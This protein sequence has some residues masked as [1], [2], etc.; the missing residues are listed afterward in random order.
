MSSHRDLLR[1]A[2]GDTLVRTNLEGVGE[3]REGKVRDLYLQPGRRLLVSTDRLSAFD[4][5]LATIPYKGQV[6]NQLAAWWF[7]Q[8][9]DLVDHHV[10]AVPDPNVTVGREAVALPVEIVVR[11]YITGVT[12]TSLWSLYQAGP[13]PYGLDLPAGL[14]KNDP[15]PDLV[16][17]PTTKAEHGGHDTPLSS[18]DV[19]AR[20]LVDAARWDEVCRTA[21]ALFRRGQ[22]RAAAAGMILVDTKYEM[23]L[24]GDRLCLI[25]EVHTP[26]SSRWWMADGYEL[27]MSR[28]EEPEGLD[29]EYV[30]RW[31]RSVGYGGDGP[32]PVM[33][34]DVRVELASRYVTAWE[35]LTGRAFVPA[36]LPAEPRI[37]AALTAWEVA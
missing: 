30:R 14:R 9:A 8:V 28:G 21:L 25:D 19:V 7:E 26:D 29:K 13:R 3:R 15:L 24:V 33:P 4:R 35:R 10:V 6:L 22:E 37:R 36:P 1:D 27:A 17:T 16:I 12:D 5:V 32:L 2:L 31:L 23:G 18:D 11:A 20:G 34:D